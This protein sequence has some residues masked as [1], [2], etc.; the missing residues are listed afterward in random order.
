MM[1][2]QR[3]RILKMN[4]CVVCGRVNPPCGWTDPII[5]VTAY[6]STRSAGLVCADCKRERDVCVSLE[7]EYTLVGGD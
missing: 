2:R 7:R 1:N 3:E 4:T 5:V 6:N